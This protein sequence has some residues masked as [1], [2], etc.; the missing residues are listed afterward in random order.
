MDPQTL[1]KN[2]LTELE[3][4]IGPKSV[5]M[6][7]RNSYLEIVDKKTLKIFLPNQ[8]LKEAVNSKYFDKIKPALARQVKT[9]DINV[10]LE[11]GQKKVDLDTEKL[12]PLF[13]SAVLPSLGSASDPNFQKS[14]LSPKYVFETYVVGSTNN[15]AH[16][17]GLG[18]VKNPGKEYNPFFIYGGVGVGKTHLM[19]AIG[20]ELYRKNPETKMIYTSAESFMN[21]L[22]ESIK[23][24][25][26]EQF[27][28]KY[29]TL[30]LLM[31]DDIQLISGKESTQDEIFHTFNSLHQE[32]KQ[33]ILTSDRRPD[34]IEKVEQRIISRFMGGLTV[35][36]Q[37]PD[38]E[39]RTA[40]LNEKLE[41]KGEHWERELVEYIAA[42]VESNVREL[43]GTLN[44]I[45]AAAKISG[46]PVTVDFIKN[47]LGPEKESRA[48]KK[49]SRVA[50]KQV[51]DAVAKHYGIR[52]NDLLSEKRDAEFVK[53]RQVAM[54]ILRDECQIKL[55][56]VARLLNKKDHTT[57]IHGANKILALYRTD[58]HIRQELITIKRDLWG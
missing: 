5:G 46:Q 12:G 27:R 42:Q 14:H 41:I 31:I 18:V 55:V 37:P 15:F 35:D 23:G 8:A 44:R 25:G 4:D 10:V 58:S 49:I 52:S 30:D 51:I 13:E 6:Y 53:P 17:G 20:N 56:E 34:E 1:W 22:I 36:I 47:Q 33:I 45:L 19:Q 39:M 28:K 29:R 43:E 7:L 2:T 11:V 48:V 16:A 26:T 9:T 40:I 21:E 50:P 54:Y 32:D 57:V 3:I 24:K 38:F